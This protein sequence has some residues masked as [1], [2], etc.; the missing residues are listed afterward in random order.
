MYT[1]ALTALLSAQPA[2]EV[3]IRVKFDTLTVKDAEHL[4]GKTVVTTFTVG[5]PPFTWGEGKNLHTVTAPKSNG[6]VDRT[7]ILKGNRLHDADLGAKLTVVGTLRIIRH[8]AR[9]VGTMALGP[10]TELRLE[11]E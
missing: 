7:V 1:L 3:V 8:P 9:M 5:G 4:D 10:W 2:D 6:A 11:E